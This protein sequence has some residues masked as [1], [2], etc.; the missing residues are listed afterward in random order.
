MGLEIERAL[1]DG[2]LRVGEFNQNVQLRE[3][4]GAEEGFWGQSQS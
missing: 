4:R 1:A 3:K 2:L